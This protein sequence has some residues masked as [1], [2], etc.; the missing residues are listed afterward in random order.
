[1]RRQDGHG[2][3][4]VLGCLVHFTGEEVELPAERGEPDGDLPALHG[5]QR[6]SELARGLHEFLETDHRARVV[7][8]LG[9]G[10]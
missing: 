1:M 6:G 10:E 9:G 4:E 3:A 2:R 7:P 8:A 5:L